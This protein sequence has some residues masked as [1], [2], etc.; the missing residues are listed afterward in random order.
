MFIASAIDTRLNCA[1]GYML[2]I[3]LVHCGA[4]QVYQVQQV[5]LVM[6][7]GTVDQVQKVSNWST[8]VLH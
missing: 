2:P 1:N 4:I 3:F 7:V 5:T 8:N 6:M